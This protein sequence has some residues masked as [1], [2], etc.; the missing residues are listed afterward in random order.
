M[1][2]VLVGGIVDGM[3]SFILILYRTRRQCGDGEIVDIQSDN[4]PAKWCCNRIGTISLS[5]SVYVHCFSY[6]VKEVLWY[7]HSEWMRFVEHLN[8]T[9]L[10]LSK[11][12][13]EHSIFVVIYDGVWYH[14]CT[15]AYPVSNFYSPFE[16]FIDSPLWISTTYMSWS[17]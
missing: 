8:D 12:R 4:D 5:V 11:R 15:I 10:N 2:R 13:M 3:L 16:A 9:K 1:N 7:S 17:I 6:R 14:F